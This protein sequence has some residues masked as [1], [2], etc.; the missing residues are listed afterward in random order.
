MSGRAFTMGNED[1]GVVGDAPM[2]VR[3]VWP[4]GLDL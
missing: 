2:S 4:S 3:V 1:V